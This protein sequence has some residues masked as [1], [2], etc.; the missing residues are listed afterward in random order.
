MIPLSNK[1]LLGL[2][3]LSLATTTATAQS[4]LS[5]YGETVL[6]VGDNAPGIPG[7]TIF[8]T[9][10][11]DAPLLDQ[12]GTLV[13]RARLTGAVTALDDRAYFLG[14]ANGDLQS[15]VRGGDPAP[16]LPGI[17]LRSATSTVGLS[18]QPRISAYGE[19][20]YFQSTISDAPGGSTVTSANDTA[21]FWGPVGGL[22]LLAREGD[23]VPFVAV[24]PPA[25]G[26]LSFT[27]AN[28]TMNE[29]GNVLF[30]TQ[31]VGGDV[32]IGTNDYAV[33]TGTPGSLQI[34][35]R[36]GDT[37]PGGEVVVP[38][39][40]STVLSFIYQI[41]AAGQVLHEMKFAAGPGGVGINNDRAL[42][43]WTPGMGDTIIAREGQQAP[44]LPTGVLF[45]DTVSSP[46]WS[47]GLSSNSF[48]RFGSTAFTT[49]L[50]GGGAVAGVDG[51]AVYY[52][53][54]LSGLTPV[55]RQGDPAPGLPGVTWGVA[56]N[57]SV[58]CNDAGDVCCVAFLGG[59]ATTADDSCL[60]VGSFANP[61][62]VAREGDLVPGM[63]A[64]VNGPWRYGP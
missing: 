28:N 54:P 16:G 20:L 14:R 48:N 2:V 3:A 13:F 56:A 15:V 24:N 11:F 40:G 33:V 62:I 18:G 60:V 45:Q 53:G 27:A 35:V 47:P 17:F 4:L 58:Q 52:G 63:A 37:L 10:N 19:I 1:H 39:S 36:K 64:T 31:L 25:Y 8:A 30:A 46:G 41:N 9:S 6:A 21:Q 29:S 55:F 7:A 34:V 50:E 57:A 22:T 32:T 42:A 38:V 44:G 49:V 59:A 23:T 5:Q 61:G 12:N 51:F 26:N 43:V